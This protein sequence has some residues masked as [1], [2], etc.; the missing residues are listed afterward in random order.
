MWTRRKV[1][2]ALGAVAAIAPLPLR[3]SLAAPTPDLVLRLTAAPE[4]LRLW[5]GAETGVLRYTGEVLSGRTDALRPMTSYLGPTLE[6]RRGERVRIEFRNRLAEPSIIHW[7]GMLVPE[8]ADGHP[9]FAIGPGGEYVYEFTVRNSAGTYL[10]HPHPHGRTGSQVYRGLAGLLIV[11]EAQEQTWGL[12]KHELSLVIQ[13]RRVGEQNEFVFKRMMMDDMTGV[14]G[15]KILVN[16]APDAAFRV[17]P[18]RYRLR[19]ANVSNAR[20]Y[21][22]AWSD[23]RPMQVI[24]TDNGVLSAAEGIQTHPYVV[25][26]PFERI[27]LLEDFGARREAAEIALVSRAFAGMEMMDMMGGGMRGMMGGMMTEPGQGAEL[28][29]AHFTVAPGARVSEETLRLP[30]IEPGAPEG[31]VVLYTRLSFR[32]MQGFLNDRRFEMTAV[33]DDERL[34][35]G[36]ASVWTFANDGEGMAMPHPMHIHGVRFRIL[37][38]TG[39][40]APPDLRDGLV[41]VGFKDTV[42]VFPGERVRLLVAPTEPG[43]FMYH[44]HN[45]EH[46]DGGMMRNCLFGERPRG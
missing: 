43:L 20:I 32:H 38:R 44:C 35:L 31:S 9:R 8:A 11:R 17:A 15:D 37:D 1:L 21:K 14:L 6:L 36:E 39:N 12:P 10:Y 3:R 33:A 13:D 23:D 18:R 25:L 26:A 2:K 27:E 34:P 22:L 5:P 30:P 7:H 29:L 45:L 24:A 41:N 4:H 42:L 28:T 19:L 46:E 16:G 40:G